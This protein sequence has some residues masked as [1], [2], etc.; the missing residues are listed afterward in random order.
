MS[1]PLNHNPASGIF[2]TKPPRKRKGGS[3][4]PLR[5]PESEFRAN[6]PPVSYVEKDAKH[7]FLLDL[8]GS[9]EEPEHFRRGRRA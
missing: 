2:T 9:Q 5:D 3:D 7:Y 6:G 8:Y 1:N 4:V